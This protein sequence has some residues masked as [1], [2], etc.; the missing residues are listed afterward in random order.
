MPTTPATTGPVWSPTQP[1]SEAPGSVRCYLVDH[2]ERRQ[3][4]VHRV[5]GGPQGQSARTHVRIANGLHLLEAVLHH[6]VVE[7]REVSVQDIDELVGGE[8]FRRQR[9][10]DEIGEK[11]RDVFIVPGREFP[12]RRE[13]VG[14]LLRQDV[15]QQRLG[16]LP[17]AFYLDVARRQLA[18]RRRQC[19]SGVRA[20]RP[21]C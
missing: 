9:E 2:L 11:N 15:E 4:R 8:L 21:C 12:V 1:S 14:H 3:R 19:L 20:S 18:V 5:R 16:H 6:D 10:P 7:G 17:L 13:F